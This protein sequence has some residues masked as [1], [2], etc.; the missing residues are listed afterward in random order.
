[1]H[2]SRFFI[3]RKELS[4]N[5]SQIPSM[6]LWNCVCYQ[7]ATTPYWSPKDSRLT[8]MAI[9]KAQLIHPLTIVE[10]DTDVA[11][12][13]R[14]VELSPLVQKVT[15]LKCIC[16][17]NLKIYL[18]SINLD[19][20]SSKII[21]NVVWN[22]IEALANQIEKHTEQAST[23]QQGIIFCDQ[24]NWGNGSWHQQLFFFFC[25]HEAGPQTTQH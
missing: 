4:P 16:I 6:S 21:W 14:A 10:N 13:S 9:L 8:I 12:S 1:M 11:S 17:Q 3:R 20:A 23:Q 7:E 25:S 22:I 24:K 18:S 2:R 15:Y 19:K 5:C